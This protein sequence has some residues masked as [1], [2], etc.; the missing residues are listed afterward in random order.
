MGR[1]LKIIIF[2][3]DLSLEL[4]PHVSHCTLSTDASQVP[5]NECLKSKPIFFTP[6]L[7]F[8]CPGKWP[9]YSASWAPRWF[10]GKESTCQCRRRKRHGSNPWIGKIPWRRKWQPTLVFFHGR[11]NRQ[12]SL[13]GYNPWGCKRVR[14]D[15]ATQT[16]TTQP[17]IQARIPDVTLR[18]HTF[19]SIFFVLR[20][21]LLFL[22][23]LSSAL[24]SL[25]HG[26]LTLD[27]DCSSCFQPRPIQYMVDRVSSLNDT[28]ELVTLLIKI[29][30]QLSM[31]YRI[32]FKLLHMTHMIWP[33]PISLAL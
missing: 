6:F 24:W 16:T 28:S 18:I 7:T 13:A 1:R 5:R 11:S 17:V 20:F 27:S 29:L 12:R 21:L 23:M 19:S 4:S 30:T 2:S 14:H 32:T 15:W 10:S 25:S 22:P 31:A 9:Y 8:I 3:S 26:L 33:S